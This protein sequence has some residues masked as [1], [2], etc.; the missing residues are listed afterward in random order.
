MRQAREMPTVALVFLACLSDMAAAAE[1]VHLRVTLTPEHL[2]R[3]T[4][5]GFG[6]QIDSPAG[7]VP[8]PLTGVDVRYPNNLGIALSGVG[9]ETCSLETLE[10]AGSRDCPVDS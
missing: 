10:V 3:G 2:G 6:L 9:V 7:Q 4:T 5:I 8:P 1:P